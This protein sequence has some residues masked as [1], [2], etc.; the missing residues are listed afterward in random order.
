M[1]HV[2]EYHGTKIV[3]PYRWL[4]EDVRTS[5]TVADWVEAQNDVTFRF[6]ESIPERAT[7]H[8]R[9]TELWDFEK[10]GTPFKAG[11]RYYYSYNSGLQ[12]QYVLYTMDSIDGEPR[13]LI[14]PNTWSEDGTVALAGTA[15]SDDGKYVAYGIQ[16]AGSDWRT[17]RIME[18]ETGRVLDD[19][20]EMDQ[21]FRRLLD[22]GQQGL[23]LRPLT[24][25]P[26]KDDQFQSLNLNQKIYYHRVG[27]PQSDDV[28]VYKRPDHPEWGFQTSVTEDGR[29][30]IIT[31]WK[32]TDDKYR[33]LYKDLDRT[34]R[35][36][37]RA[38]RQLRPRVHVCR[39]R[40]PGFLLQD[41]RAMLRRSV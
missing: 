10:F 35:D 19:Q 24:T 5:K 20:S 1:E 32:G 27:T 33:V 22:Q 13:V 11:G 37:D 6:L 14:D 16:D 12:N 36:A 29:Y 40:R 34:V 2:D 30:L 7:L 38:D 26:G 21:V 28:L 31:V 17:W 15:F 18:I 8:N 9:L 4:E 3:D 23:L 25:K 41:R 39:Q